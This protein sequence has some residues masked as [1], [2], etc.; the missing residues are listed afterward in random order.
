MSR[1]TMLAVLAAALCG[2]ALASEFTSPHIVHLTS[3][4]YEEQTGDGKVYFIKYYA[5]WCGHCKRLAGTWKELAKDLIDVPN[6]V[7]AHVDC[8]TDRDVCT[9]AQIKGYPTLKIVHKGEEV[10]AYRGSRDKDSLKAFV[11]ET[12][13]QLT[14][15]S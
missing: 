10:N 2:A 9:S 14:S 6:V 5:P 4:N 3:S 7:I 1:F 8:T 15:D 12:V 13:K 11:E